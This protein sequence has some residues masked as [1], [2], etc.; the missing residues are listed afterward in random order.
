MNK[1]Q[2][3]E[4]FDRQARMYERR[5]KQKAQKKWREKLL[6]S[7]GGKVLEVAVGAGANFPFYPREVEVTAVDFSP[8]MLK[9]AKEA[10]QEYGIR[11]EWILSDV[12]NLSFPSDS[13]DTIVSTLSLCGYENPDAV[14]ERFN[15][16]CKK[17]GQILL[18]EHG[19][20]SI[21]PVTWLQR[22]LDPLFYRSIGCH[23][24][25]EIL[26]LVKS[27]LLIEKYESHWLNSVHMIWAK[28]RK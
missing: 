15:Y 12:E 7:A 24:N 26:S 21:R 9:R 22:K 23:Q 20:S 1:H 13:F 14:L 19:I 28:P 3:I 16:W 8:E 25:R 4:I 2:L 5:R 11:T 10:A 6:H 27:H 18:L 17:D